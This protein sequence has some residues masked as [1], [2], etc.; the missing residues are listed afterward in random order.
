MT[1]DEAAS[2]WWSIPQA[3][4]W[5]V[6]RSEAQ[7]VRAGRARTLS[8]V[9]RLALPPSSQGADPPASATAAV[10][11]LRQAWQGRRIGVAG[12]LGGRAAAAPVPVAADL[13]F[14]DHRGEVCLGEDGLY[15]GAGR[16]WSDLW[17][18]AEV[19]KRCWSGGPQAAAGVPAAP[20]HRR[21]PPDG[22][23]VRFMQDRR[24]ALRAAGRKAGRE[25]LLKE[26]MLRFGL[27]RKVALDIWN[28]APHDRKGGRPKRARSP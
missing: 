25:E 9:E 22:E 3:V 18:R 2:A 19:C 5:I 10:E 17:V 8:Q 1:G 12:R 27:Q 16:F 6:T 7:V 23:V 21:P 4:V 28:R 20:R 24:N 13:R 15:R 26:A 11:A 14:Q